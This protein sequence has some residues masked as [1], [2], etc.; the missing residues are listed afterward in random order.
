M[1]RTS[2]TSNSMR[3][4]L[5]GLVMLL[6]LS[7]AKNHKSKPM[8]KFS[9][10]FG[11]E[12]A[13]SI[14]LTIEFETE[15][16]ATAFEGAGTVFTTAVNA[17]LNKITSKIPGDLVSAAVH[18]AGGSQPDGKDVNLF[19]SIELPGVVSMLE[20]TEIIQDNLQGQLDEMVESIPT[21][22]MNTLGIVNIT[23]LESGAEVPSYSF[24][25]SVTLGLEEAAAELNLDEEKLRMMT[26]GMNT[27]LALAGGHVDLLRPAS[28]A[29]VMDGTNFTINGMFTLDGL[30]NL[31][32]FA[33]DAIKT[34]VDEHANDAIQTIVNDFGDSFQGAQ[35]LD[36]KLGFGET[37]DIPEAETSENIV[38]TVEMNNTEMATTLKDQE[39]NINLLLIL[40][41]QVVAPPG[42][43]IELADN[44]LSVEGNKV[45]LKLKSK[46]L[47]AAS[48]TEADEV[49][50]DFINKI[51]TELIPAYMEQLN[52]FIGKDEL[53]FSTMS[54]KMLD[55]VATVEADTDESQSDD[56]NDGDD[57]TNDGDDS[58]DGDSDN[59]G[60][61]ANAEGD[62]EDD[63]NTEESDVVLTVSVDEDIDEDVINSWTADGG[64]GNA[65]LDNFVSDFEATMTEEVKEGCRSDSITG[66]CDS[67]VVKVVGLKLASSRRKLLASQIDVTS[68]VTNAPKATIESVS[69][70]GSVGNGKYTVVFQSATFTNA[71]AQSS[72]L[73]LGM[74]AAAVL[75]VFIQM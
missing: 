55:A 31:P 54:I 38:V 63:P 17:L 40:L 73:S 36:V 65:T 5:I 46:I 2:M 34:F 43:I 45:M 16:K 52:R 10:I 42:T 70:D 51:D 13:G 26:K 32:E 71:A 29:I 12:P 37:P 3:T 8:P 6:G 58:N 50:K 39:A 68:R 30:S 21:A 72:S 74:L 18:A 7:Q 49:I 41:E 28:K 53:G 14:G 62:D 22:A 75:L 33:V 24:T 19:I 64:S 48:A 25:F 56:N 1:G 60:D 57:S 69:S 4:A 23:G 59:D 15:A 9:E 66:N 67:A 47:G 35:V 61:D 44:A 11:R 20:A 27:L